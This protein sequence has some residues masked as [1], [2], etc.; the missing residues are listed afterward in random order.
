M[1][2][3]ENPFFIDLVHGAV[4]RHHDNKPASGEGLVIPVYSPV[5]RMKKREYPYKC[6]KDG[7]T[8]PIEPPEDFPGIPRQIVFVTETVQGESPVADKLDD[9]IDQGI[10][11]M[12]KRVR[13]E[14]FRRQREHRERKQS[15]D[16]FDDVKRD[17][18]QRPP[19]RRREDSSKKRKKKKRRKK[20]KNNRD[21]G[22][23]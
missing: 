11:Q 16:L 10:S 8:D 22:N 19:R 7:V 5:G 13:D 20:S 6:P 18:Q 14:K 3:P 2:L 17:R 1:S 12:R 23:R 4:G 15:E 21:R 9:I